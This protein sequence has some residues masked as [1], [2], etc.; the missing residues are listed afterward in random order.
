MLLFG[1]R[2]AQIEQTYIQSVTPSLVIIYVHVIF[3]ECVLPRVVFLNR[4]LAA[5]S[6]M[7]S[8]HAEA[9][10]PVLLAGRNCQSFV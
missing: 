4:S 1:P 3:V 8:D 6:N 10:P 2:P 5:I 9:F 7:L